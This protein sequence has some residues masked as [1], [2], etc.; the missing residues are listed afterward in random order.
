MKKFSNIYKKTLAAV[1]MIVTLF[2]LVACGKNNEGKNLP[3]GAV[4]LC[5]EFSSIDPASIVEYENSTAFSATATDGTPI[6]FEG[7]GI[8]VENGTLVMM[9]GS[10]LFSLDY[11]GQLLQF[12]PEADLPEFELDFGLA[13]ANEPHPERMTDLAAALCVSNLTGNPEY[14]SYTDSFHTGFLAMGPDENTPQNIAINR[15]IM[16]VDTTVPQVMFRDLVPGTEAYDLLYGNM[17]Y[18]I[19]WGNT[20]VYDAGISI[21]T[22]ALQKIEEPNV[23]RSDIIAGID[24][25]SIVKD[26]S[27]TFFSSTM[28]DG[29]IVRFEGENIKIDENGILIAPDS[30]ITSLDAVG[31]IYGYYPVVEDRGKYIGKTTD[32]HVGYAYTYS[33]SKTSVERAKEVHTYSAFGQQVTLLDGQYLLPVAVFSPN[34][35]NFQGFSFGEGEFYVS[36]LVACYDPTEKV[37]R[38][39]EAK[40]NEYFSGAYLEGERYDA[41]RETSA[42]L[43]KKK[44][45]FYLVLKPDTEVA[46][47]ADNARSVYYVP[48]DFYQVGALRDAA[49]N[50][51]AKETALISMGDTL[52]ITVGDSTIQMPLN[53][54]ARYH[55][56]QTMNDLV[57]FAYPKS[58]G[59]LNTLVVPVIWADQTDMA[60]DNTLK[61][62]RQGIGRIADE[63]GNVTDYS[64]FTDEKFSLSEYYDIASYGKMKVTSFMTDWYYASENFADIW[65]QSPTD[66]YSNDIM[67]WVRATYPDIDW[68]KYDQDRN[69]YIDSMLI[70]NAGVKDSD[71]VIIV[72]Y[73][74]AFNYLHTYYGDH[75][76]TP[77]APRVN[78]FTN[79]GYDW[80]QH[81][82]ATII[83]EFAHGLGLIDYYDVNYSGIDAVG[84]FDMQSQSYG[85]WNAYSKLAV[86]WMNPQ[87]VSG[88][89]SGQS[90]EFTLTSSALTDD[91]LI[92]PAAGKEYEG[93][94]S[95]YIMLD[96]FTD[97]GTNEY[98]TARFNLVDAAGVRIS[99]VNAEMEQR[100]TTVES[101][102]SPGE[103]AEYTIGTI[104]TANNYTGNKTGKYNIEVVQNGGKNTFT[105]IEQLDT[106][107]SK[108]DLFYAG[109]TFTAEDYSE[110][111]YQGRMDDGS[112]FGYSIKILSIGT[113]GNGIPTAK[114]R[115]TRR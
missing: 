93:P 109:D 53:V 27:T 36:S 78:T 3:A 22:Y 95:E 115:V 82:Y 77:D 13:F 56:A 42:D 33:A 57:P 73:S 105:N 104:H 50:E 17:G 9:P 34:F 54:V 91:M 49:G 39:T 69:G 23:L 46:N 61:L 85:D 35:F 38:M 58:L 102:T 64:V 111:L 76:G 67:D 7:I 68:E 30:K 19:D 8:T 88:L 84:Q 86:G 62:F 83:H 96:L 97:D 114:I 79:V 11:Y 75:V 74:G 80:I 63:N 90:A 4:E 40:L 48:K 100:T 55:G 14:P 112:E 43:E 81:D 2:S 37:T 32:F 92:I 12:Y 113:D 6:R 1:L 10:K 89:T 20:Q 98:D 44:F 71:E 52:D 47:M 106:T 31:K 94:F 59:E 60:N 21:E 41:S 110:F 101:A 65:N 5:V 18:R 24:H 51:L 45:D 70:L 99:H 108:Q 26:G 72:S 29:T 15:L 25:N 103:S 66:T 87:I 107:L 28:S 16:L